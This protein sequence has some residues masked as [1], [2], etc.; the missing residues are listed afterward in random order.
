MTEVDA[1]NTLLGHLP[2]PGADVQ[3]QK[4]A[5]EAARN[6]NNARPAFRAP[7]SVPS[8]LP[9]ELRERG[10]AFRQ[11]PDVLAA[12]QSMDWSVGMADLLQVLSF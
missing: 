3:Q 10:A 9:E 7:D 1:L 12:F 5:W 4:E 2:T 11:R 6:A 8:D